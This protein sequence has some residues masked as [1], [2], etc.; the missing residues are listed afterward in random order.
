MSSSVGNLSDQFPIL[1]Q[2]RH[3]DQDDF[4]IAVFGSEDDT[5]DA[6][7]ERPFLLNNFD[8][9]VYLPSVFKNQYGYEAISSGSDIY[10]LD[11]YKVGDSSFIN[12]YSSSTNSWN[13]LPPLNKEKDMGIVFVLLCRS[14]L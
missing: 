2:N 5:E 1:Y 14:C 10:L 9:K 13:R 4:S 8:T 3:C 6:R 12:M 7:Y 11:D